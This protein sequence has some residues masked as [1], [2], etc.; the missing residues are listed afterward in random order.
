MCTPREC[1]VALLWTRHRLFAISMNV[2]IIG[3]IHR[4]LEAS[5]AVLDHAERQGAFAQA[6]CLGDV[7]GYGPDPGACINLLRGLA[8]ITMAG[9]H[10]HASVG[11]LAPETFNPYAAQA[12]RWT[13]DNLSETQKAYIRELPLVCT[14]GSFTLVHGSLRDP[15]WEYLLDEEAARATFR[16]LQNQ[17]CLVSHSHL[18]FICLE[19][20]LQPVFERL[21]EGVGMPLG[22][23]R[24]II[25]PGS[26]GQP[27]DGDPR[28]AYILYDTD[29]S[30]VTL[31]RVEYDI[32]ATQEKMGR[33]ALP[34]PLIARLAVGR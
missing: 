25:N 14:E 6:W 3:D 21:P 20:N 32:A 13:A 1:T 8:P 7:V 22:G 15:I 30:T 12:C 26:V 29:S 31:H 24:T 4:N 33:A 10:D 17:V 23:E 2:L 5:Q 34:A 19:R 11:L 16:L 18:P 28:A 9:N 27:R